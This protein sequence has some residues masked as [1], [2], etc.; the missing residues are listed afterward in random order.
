MHQRGHGWLRWHY[1]RNAL[2]HYFARLLTE[3]QSWV[4][5]TQR[6]EHRQHTDDH[7]A[8]LSS[9]LKFKTI[10]GKYVK[11]L[12][13]YVGI[14]I[15]WI[16]RDK[17]SCPCMRSLSPFHLSIHLVN[18][19]WHGRLALETLPVW[20]HVSTPYKIGKC[21][22]CFSCVV[23]FHAKESAEWYPGRLIYHK[24]QPTWFS[25]Y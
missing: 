25:L 24:W 7:G 10:V 18:T 3:Y 13:G 4:T 11:E 22:C 19:D 17:P 5:V 1:K 21:W 14:E 20:I 6:T 12:W 9:A 23:Q 15:T 2:L 16:P 8:G